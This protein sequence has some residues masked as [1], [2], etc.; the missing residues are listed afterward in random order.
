MEGS[1]VHMLGR[2]CV[3]EVR[4]VVVGLM[5]VSDVTSVAKEVISH[6][7]AMR[8]GGNVVEIASEDAGTLHVYFISTPNYISVNIDLS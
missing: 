8:Y 6:A 2:E 1:G 3:V 7:I 5:L 4:D